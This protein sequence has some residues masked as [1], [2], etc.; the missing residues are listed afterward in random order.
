MPR[1]NNLYIISPSLPTDTPWG[2]A[3]GDPSTA[4][5]ITSAPT[6]KPYFAAGSSFKDSWGNSV[7]GIGIY[8]GA[9]DYFSGASTPPFI[10]A[11]TTGL[12]LS[13]GPAIGIVMETGGKTGSVL[14]NAGTLIYTAR[15]DQGSTPTYKPSTAYGAYILAES[16][17][18]TMFSNNPASGN[19]PVGGIIIDNNAAPSPITA[20][21]RGAGVYIYAGTSAG[22]Q[23]AYAGFNSSG[24]TF[25]SNTA[26]IQQTISDT[27]ITISA[28]G[29]VA[30]GAKTYGQWTDGSIKL[31]A[32]TNVYG[33]FDTT[34]GI[35]LQGGS[36]PAVTTPATTA[37][38][39]YIQTNSTGITLLGSPTSSSPQSAYT[40]GSKIVL[41][42]A[43]NSVNIFGL[44]FQGNNFSNGMSLTSVNEG[45]SVF[46][47]GALAR[48]RMLVEDPYD[49]MT[50]VGM[51]VYYQ[52][53]ALSPH[54]STNVLIE[55]SNSGAVGDLWVTY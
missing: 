25:Q 41:G 39:T 55:G 37:W 15:D 51:A 34:N 17:K 24:I 44:P 8:T 22:S 46:G 2:S 9:W 14:S 27:A 33:T 13:A 10:T 43:T 20:T 36:V 5:I 29:S 26:N 45:N 50:R 21:A 40:Q 30:T 31:Q 42:T 23:K 47:L 53:S 4:G 1:N 32:D 7:S 18:I 6:S 35:Y 38:N 11:T 19:W 54:G 49:G 16:K 52:D 28:G 48:Q 12:Q 3:K